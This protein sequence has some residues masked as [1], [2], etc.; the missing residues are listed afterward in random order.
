MARTEGTV[1]ARPRKSPAQRAQM[2]LDAA[3][4]RR[5][6]AQAKVDKLEAGLAPARQELDESVALADY[7]SK[8]PL[9]PQNAAAADEGEPA[10]D[11]EGA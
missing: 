7:L 3:I 2:D 11:D 9:L 6:A 8:N 4:K 10:P 1:N 5:D